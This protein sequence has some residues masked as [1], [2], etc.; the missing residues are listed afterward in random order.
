MLIV[1]DQVGSV[2]SVF[3][4]I[5]RGALAAA[6]QTAAGAVQG[7]GQTIGQKLRTLLSPGGT[8]AKGAAAASSYMPYVL[9]GVAVLGVGYLVMRRH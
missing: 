8:G 9:G 7:A 1:R 2:G 6:K 4:D 5:G 3:K